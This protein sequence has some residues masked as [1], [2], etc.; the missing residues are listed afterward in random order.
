MVQAQS[1]DV[2]TRKPGNSAEIEHLNG[3]IVK[4]NTIRYAVL[5]NLV[6]PMRDSRDEIMHDCVLYEHVF[7]NPE[8]VQFLPTSI[9]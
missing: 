2:R 7:V 1:K 6:N 5:W 9:M 4:P 8:T 3:L